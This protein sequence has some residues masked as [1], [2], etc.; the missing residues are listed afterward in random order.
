L[1]KAD[2]DVTRMVNEFRKRRDYIVNALNSIP[3]FNCL[4]PKGA[5]Y[6][7]PEFTLPKTSMELATTLV[8]HGVIC[9]PGSAFG[10]N[11]ER[12]IRFSYANSLENIKKAIERVTNVIET[13][14]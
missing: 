9:T 5:F 11:G 13:L 7:F 12:H 2:A 10:R 4:T 8:Q 3:G 14:S 1:K 6:V